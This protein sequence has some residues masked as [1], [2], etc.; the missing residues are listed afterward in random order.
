MTR[1][2]DVVREGEMGH[3]QLTDVLCSAWVSDRRHDGR[4]NAGTGLRHQGRPNTVANAH[5]EV[6]RAMD[7]KSC[8]QCGL[9]LWPATTVCPRCGQPQSAAA[10]GG[11]QEESF[12]LAPTPP[13]IRQYRSF[14][15]ITPVTNQHLR[16]RGVL[17]IVIGI[18]F[19]LTAAITCWASYLSALHSHSAPVHT[20]WVGGFIVGGAF[21]LRGVRRLSQL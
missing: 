21:I 14:A 15:A 8:T 10:R 19:V 13:P 2:G 20:I 6:G 1:G 18:A 5:M 3:E 4:S 7:A 12:V 16:N 9:G 17:L 11:P